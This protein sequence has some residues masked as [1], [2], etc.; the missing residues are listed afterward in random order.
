MC[1]SPMS[2]ETLQASDLAFVL[3]E[4]S[5]GQRCARYRRRGFS[6]PRLSPIPTVRSPVYVR[7]KFVIGN[8]GD[9]VIATNVALVQWASQTI[10]A[11]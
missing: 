8:L 7:S 9:G 1:L 11:R 2:P 3:P 4:A 10:R 6:S 5:P